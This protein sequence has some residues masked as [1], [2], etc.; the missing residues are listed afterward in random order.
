MY[1]N[2]KKIRICLKK[3]RKMFQ[4]LVNFKNSTKMNSFEKL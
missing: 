3:K 1:G 4:N 2:P